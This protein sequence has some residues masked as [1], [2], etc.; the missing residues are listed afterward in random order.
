MA[1]VLA[2]P[3]CPADPRPHAPDVSVCIA[4]WNCVELLR[5]CLQSLFDQPQGVRVRSGRRGQRLDRRRRGHGRRRVPAGGAVRNADEPR[6]RR[7]QQPGRRGR[8]RPVPLLPEQRHASSRRTP[9]GSSSTSPRRTRPSGWSARGSAAPTAQFQISYRR[10]P[11]LGGAAPPR[12]PAA[13]DRAVP[14]GV[15]RVPPRRRSTRRGAAGRGADGGGGVPAAGGVRG[16]RPVGRAVP[17]SA[18][19]DIDLSTQVGP[20]RGR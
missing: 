20:A 1:Q 17:A 12:Q 2:A 7:R 15:L 18:V 5:R 8:P 16:M 19:E 14:P 13:L 9:S 11:T 10:R 4:N 3:F 6:V